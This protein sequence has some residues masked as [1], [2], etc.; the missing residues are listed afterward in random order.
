MEGMGYWIFLAAM[1]LL[2]AFMK[3]RQRQE[4]A[5]QDPNVIAEKKPNP[6]QAEF[7]Q[8]LFGDMKDI[9]NEPTE[10]VIEEISDDDFI[11]EEIETEADYSPVELDHVVF[12]DLSATKIDS[13]RGKNLFW[14]K[15]I[16]RKYSYRPQFINM[17]DVKRAI[18]MKEI[19]DKPRELRKVIR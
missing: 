2:S 3:K 8:D 12:K 13:T 15:K 10:D 19:L 11:E 17:D 18:V 14:N 16:K 6:F 5:D 4:P 7:L 9:I 1:Y